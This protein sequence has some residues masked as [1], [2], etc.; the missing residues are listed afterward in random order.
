MDDISKVEGAWKVALSVCASLDL[1]AQ[2]RTKTEE[3]LKMTRSNLCR[4]RTTQHRVIR[5]FAVGRAEICHGRL[6][7]EMTFYARNVRGCRT[8]GKTKMIHAKGK[9][10]ELSPLLTRGTMKNA[11]EIVVRS[12]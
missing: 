2:M 4:Q 9:W 12:F 6:G 7:C 3:G 5:A 10:A 11:S 8:F 1:P